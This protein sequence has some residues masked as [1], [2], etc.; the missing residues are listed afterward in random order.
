MREREDYLL[1]LQGLLVHR[2]AE[3]AALQAERDSL[4]HALQVLA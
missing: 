1:Y 3:V 2:D 4:R